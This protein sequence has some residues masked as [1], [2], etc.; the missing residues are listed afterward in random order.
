MQMQPLSA[1]RS[2]PAMARLAL[3]LSAALAALLLLAAAPPAQADA[4]T[5]ALDRARRCAPAHDGAALRTR[6]C[7][8]SRARRGFGHARA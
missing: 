6:V 2:P 8:F 3:L 5:D 1:P 7:A 4:Y